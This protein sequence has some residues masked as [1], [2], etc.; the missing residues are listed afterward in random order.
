LLMEV[1]PDKYNNYER[2]SSVRY[3]K[4]RKGGDSM[5]RKYIVIAFLAIFCLTSVLF[6]VARAPP[7]SQY[8]PWLDYN[9]DGYIGID[10]IFATAR[11][12]GTEGDSTKNVSVTNWIDPTIPREIDQYPV[13]LKWYIYSAPFIVSKNLLPHPSEIGLGPGV[14]ETDIL[15][16]NPSGTREVNI[17]KKIVVAFRENEPFQQPY[18]IGNLTLFPDAAFRIDSKEIT[19]FIPWYGNGTVKGFVC[20]ITTY[21]YLDVIAFYTV[22]DLPYNVT[23]SIESLTIT[24]KPW[25]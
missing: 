4:R 17:T 22:S 2:S 12:F 8:D 21:A 13:P 24:P 3:S 20:I 7:G 9:E 10:D 25:G 18:M 14:Y 5:I 11:S 23:S 19:E 1:S 15:V 16:H 6:M